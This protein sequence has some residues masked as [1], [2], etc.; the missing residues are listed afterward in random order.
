MSKS[1]R[2]REMQQ[3]INS[4]KQQLQESRKKLEEYRRRDRPQAGDNIKIIENKR[5]N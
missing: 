5:R 1:E 2:M 4:L 3:E